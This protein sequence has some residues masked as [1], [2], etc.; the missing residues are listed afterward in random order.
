MDL[1]RYAEVARRWWKVLAVGFALALAIAFVAAFR[2]GGDGLEYRT[3][4]TWQADQDILLT[5]QGFPLGRAKATLESGGGDSAVIGEGDQLAVSARLIELAGLYAQLSSSD[6]VVALMEET[7]PPV[8]GE[9]SALQFTTPGGTGLPAVRLQALAS[10]PDEAIELVRRNS[11]AF[12]TLVRE[13]QRAA[14]IP[15]SERVVL[16]TLREAQ[17]AT[18]VSGRSLIAPVV[19][20]LAT[21][22]F[23]VGLVLLLENV[24]PAR[25]VATSSDADA[26]DQTR[27]PGGV[28]TSAEPW[29]SDFGSPDAVGSTPVREPETAHA[30]VSSRDRPGNAD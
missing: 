16:A 11:E 5:T 10:S 27:E 3:S 7:G 24:R 17:V 25:A 12:E 15:A 26:P 14:E 13:R 28:D 8:E 29:R 9:L 22:A 2:I 18:E 6:A 30:A 23:T 19:A 1:R 21:L 20:F 4:A